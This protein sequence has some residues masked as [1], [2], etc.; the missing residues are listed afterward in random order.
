MDVLINAAMDE[1]Q[2]AVLDHQTQIAAMRAISYTPPERLAEAFASPGLLKELLNLFGHDFPPI[3]EGQLPPH[4]ILGAKGSVAKR[5]LNAFM[6]FRTY[7]LMLFPW[8]QQKNASGFLTQLWG[9]DP[10]RNKWALVAKVY[11]FLRDQLGKETVNLSAYLGVACPLMHIVK[12]IDYFIIFGWRAFCDEQGHTTFHQNTTSLS[13]N[14]AKLKTNEHP[15]TEIDLLTGVLSAGYFENCAQVLMMRMWACQNGI[16]TTDGAT[17]GDTVQ[18]LYEP[19][20]P[21]P[22]KVSFINAIHN[23]RN[24]AA[25]E[26]FGHDYDA[27][28]FQNRYVH[29][30]EVQNLTGFENVQISMADPPMESNALYDFTQSA[31]RLPQ[32]HEFDVYDSINTGIIDISSAWSVDRY[33]YSKQRPEDQ[34][35][36]AEPQSDSKSITTMVFDPGSP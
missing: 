4:G 7:Y 19:V 36:F 1:Q 15:T 17:T 2:V 29:S 13:E 10:H 8:A 27:E 28:F 34:Q 35:Q 21:T 24:L 5:P 12:P 6:A 23:N 32:V 3:Y 18:P 11:S 9:G 25:R 33:L 14:L 31:E 16:M 20:P 26:L 30:W 22:Y